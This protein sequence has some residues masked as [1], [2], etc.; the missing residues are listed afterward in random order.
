MCRRQPRTSVNDVDVRIMETTKHLLYYFK[1][2]L[3]EY[4]TKEADF[5]ELKGTFV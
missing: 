1:N 4:F 3:H 2:E 5:I